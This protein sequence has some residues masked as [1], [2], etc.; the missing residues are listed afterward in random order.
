MEGVS[1]PSQLP[2]AK[3]VLPGLLVKVS[4]YEEEQQ[5]DNGGYNNQTNSH[6]VHG[7]KQLPQPEG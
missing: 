6:A 2:G 1:A 4:E 3:I 7:A 5:S